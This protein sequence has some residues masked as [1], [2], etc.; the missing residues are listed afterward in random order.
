[1]DTWN[2]TEYKIIKNMFYNYQY[3]QNYLNKR[4]TT[5]S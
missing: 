4:N 3:E 5:K 2:D 1:M